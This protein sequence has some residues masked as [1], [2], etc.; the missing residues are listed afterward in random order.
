M[1]SYLHV[2]SLL[3]SL[4]SALMV[5]LIRVRATKKP[6]NAKKI[7]MPPVGMST[8]F[9]MFIA[10]FTRIP[11]TWGLL[12]FAVGAIFFSYPLIRT[13]RFYKINDEVYLHRSKAFIF[14]LLILL[15]IRMAMHT[16]I[17]E[18]VT[19]PQTG[20]IFFL[21]AFGMLLPWRLVMYLQ[22]RKLLKQESA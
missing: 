6:T 18:F 8:G 7:I 20:A 3:G 13:S 5:I 4:G 19:L 14:I 15:A 10:P 11:V 17:E 12:A 16:Y 1:T 9:L 21:L 22:Y 2:A